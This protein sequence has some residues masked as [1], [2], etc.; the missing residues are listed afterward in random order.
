MYFSTVNMAFKLPSM[1]RETLILAMATALFIATSILVFYGCR[2]RWEKFEGTM[3][4]VD[5]K[6]GAKADAADAKADAKDANAGEK[7]DKPERSDLTKQEKELFESL[8]DNTMN[9]DQVQEL[10]KQ[11]VLNEKLVEKFLAKLEEFGE[12]DTV[13]TV[14]R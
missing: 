4:P 13:D 7:A 11:G 14:K 3:D 1:R 10:V 2:C 5:A 9:E 6:D 8:K 12:E